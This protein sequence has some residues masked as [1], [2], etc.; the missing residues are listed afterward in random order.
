M[1]KRTGKITKLGIQMKKAMIDLNITQTELAKQAGT[2]QQYINDIIYGRRTGT[3][4]MPAI[5]EI[6]KLRLP[7]E[8]A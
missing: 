4:Y 5:Q 2:S 3:K 6:L 7:K 8:I 1:R